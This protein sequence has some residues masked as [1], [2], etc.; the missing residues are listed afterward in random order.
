MDLACAAAMMKVVFQGNT[1]PS[2]AFKIV[3][4]TI[5]LLAVLAIELA[6]WAMLRSRHRRKN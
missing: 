5:A 3:V 1:N 6:L 4:T 2:L